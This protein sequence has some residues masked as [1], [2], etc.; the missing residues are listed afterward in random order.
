MIVL[1]AKDDSGKSLLLP[2]TFINDIYNETRYETWMEEQLL[3]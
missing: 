2:K 3:L 1:V